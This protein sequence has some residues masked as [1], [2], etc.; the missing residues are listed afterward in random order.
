MK[1]WN[2]TRA[3]DRAIHEEPEKLHACNSANGRLA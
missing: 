1:P 2:C 3:I